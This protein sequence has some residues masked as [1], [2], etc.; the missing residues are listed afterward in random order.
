MRNWLFFSLAFVFTL[1]VLLM[2]SSPAQIT[3]HATFATKSE[4]K[5]AINVIAGDN[6]LKLLDE[7]AEIC[8]IT[9]IDEETTYSHALV[10]TGNTIQVREE[11]CGNPGQDN[12]IIKFNSY[13]D[14]L[15]S[16]SDPENFFINKKNEGYYI[17]RSNYVSEGGQLSCSSSFQETYCPAAYYYLSSSQMASAELACCANYELTDEEEV[18]I[19]EM[20]AVRTT[21]S[22]SPVD[23]IF[24]TTGVI[25]VIISIILVVVIASLLIMQPKNPI[26]D[27]VEN[28]RK[29]G[30][31]D[32]AIKNALTQAGWDEKTINQAL[33]KK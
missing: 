33:K 20:K 24:S 17:F 30:Y 14:L 22:F 15:D 19:N 27:Y 29:Q 12:I 1:M 25:I 18:L 23:F 10:K 5:A 31:D 2:L 28:A 6:A 32:Y 21:S 26:S 13:D 16:K 11:Y 3:G 7:G 8:V 9:D 4:V